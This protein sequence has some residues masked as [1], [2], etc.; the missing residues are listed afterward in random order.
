M[1]T[2]RFVFFARSLFNFSISAPL[3]P[4]MIPGRD[5]RIV[6]RSLLPGRSTSTELIPAAFKRVEQRFLKLQ[7]LVQ[8]LRIFLLGK[9]A[10][11]PG[12]GYA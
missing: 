8:K 4:M 7:I 9:P 6:M 12:L 5:V 1:K 10:R 11:T 2:S 3:R